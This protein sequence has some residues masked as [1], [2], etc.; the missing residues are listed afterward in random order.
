MLSVADIHYDAA[1]TFGPAATNP[2]VQ[3]ATLGIDAWGNLSNRSGV[4]GKTNYEGLSCSVSNKNQLTGCSLGYDAAGNVTSYGTAAYTYD[5]ENR[6]TMTAGWTYV[7]DG[8]GNRV[9]KI[10]GSAVLDWG[11]G[12]LAESDLTASATSWKEYIFFNSKRV[13]R[14]DA[15]NGSVHYLFSDHLGS[16]SVTTNST[17]ATL[18]QDRRLLPLW[19]HCLRKYFDHYLFT[20]KERDSETGLDFFGARYY[21]SNMGRFTSVDPQSITKERLLFPQKLN[22]YSYARNNPLAFVD[23]DGWDDFFVFLAA[24]AQ[25]RGTSQVNWS[26]ASESAKAQGHNVTVYGPEASTEANFRDALVSGGHVIFVGHTMETSSNQ[27]ISILVEQGNTGIGSGTIVTPSGEAKDAGMVG[28]IDSKSVALFGCNTGDLANQY[29]GPALNGIAGADAIVG[30][31]SNGK[32]GTNLQTLETAAGAF[33]KMATSTKTPDVN[34]ATSAA[35]S[36][37]KNSKKPEDKNDEVRQY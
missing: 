15:S 11:A 10:N 37:V 8:D 30:V 4:T 19:G 20:G 16:T 9:K 2:G 18:E 29:K 1:G 12:P 13:A 25:D 14:W 5:A 26:Q 35:N 17:G 24:S 33:L 34:A 6:I 31:N 22:S 28:P 36:V 32:S 21:G 23:P 3:P 7:Y 27:A